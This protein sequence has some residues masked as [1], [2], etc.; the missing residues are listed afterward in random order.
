MPPAVQ[1]SVGGT[2]DEMSVEIS[3]ALGRIEGSLQGFEVRL[4]E[5]GRTTEVAINALRADVVYANTE[6]RKQVMDHEGRIHTLENDKAARG[7]AFKLI[8]IVRDY[9]PWMCAC[10]IG[11]IAWIK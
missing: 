4:A 2:R 10:L 8:T 11:V 7:G 3:R 6:L 9:S 1:R 5:H